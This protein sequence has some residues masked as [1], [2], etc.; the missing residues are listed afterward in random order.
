MIECSGSGRWSEPVRER[1]FCSLNSRAIRG[2]LFHQRCSP[3]YN[4]RVMLLS[5]KWR[6]WLF[7]LAVTFLVPSLSAV[8]VEIREYHG[9]QIQCLHSGIR[10]SGGMGCGTFGYARVFTATVKSATEISDTDKRL[11]LIPDEIFLGSASEVTATVNQACLPLNQP[12]IKAGDK[13]LVYLQSPR[14]PGIEE[15][16]GEL[17]LPYDSP[18][19]PLSSS[20]A[21][22]NIST[23]RKLTLSTDSGII[24]GRV[25]RM[26]MT[27]QKPQS[28]PVPDW[29]VTAKRI[30][31]GTEYNALTDSNGHFEFELPPDSYNVTVNTQLGFWAPDGKTFVVKHGCID[32]DFPIHA[33]GGIS[34]T[35]TTAD[36]S[37]RRTRK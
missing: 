1:E 24:T 19:G 29:G 27:D 23:L 30:S 3:A 28:R 36:G 31:G 21:Q 9:R 18:S 20:S 32:V 13:W 8:I 5:R 11:E 14:F 37:Q 6:P 7:V 16:P 25:T 2:T 10:S 33:D 12:E 26:K 15:Q 4:D 34:G 22:E 17:V 35:V